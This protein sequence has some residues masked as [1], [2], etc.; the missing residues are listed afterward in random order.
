LMATFGTPLPKPD[1]AARALSCVLAMAARMKVLNA[2]RRA[3]GVP[4]IDAR[5]GLHFGQVILGD[6][7]ANRLEF[8]VLGDSVNVA[9]RLEALTRPLNVQIVVSDAAVQAA[10][11][12][13]DL[14]RVPDQTVRG[15]AAPIAVWTMG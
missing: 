5:F 14:Q 12:T 15:V 6:I 1:D 9:S 8:A 11:G 4:E 13:T 7:G 3:Q 2:S 10:G